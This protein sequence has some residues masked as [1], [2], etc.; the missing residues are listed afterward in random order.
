MKI[1]WWNK[2]VK[3]I[4]DLYWKIPYDY[5]LSSLYYKY[6]KNRNKNLVVPKY[7]GRHGWTD[8]CELLPHIL[9][10]ILDDF[11]QNECMPVEIIDWKASDR[12]VEVN[13]E[14]INVRDEM[15]AILE[16]WNNIYNK[17]YP[18]KC[19]EMYEEMNKCKG[20]YHFTPLEENS[21][22]CTWD[23]IYP[24]E[25]QKKRANK[26]HDELWKLER[27]ME[28]DRISYMI[29]IVNISQYLWS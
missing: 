6:W 29:R 18:Q 2:L 10:Q 19:K 22:F 21:E 27:K 7:L 24:S 13:G 23:I 28:E 8:R 11:V 15:T 20:A 3:Q 14:S 26:L 5:R 25:E 16:W 9:F 4:Q 12:R 1:K 17:E